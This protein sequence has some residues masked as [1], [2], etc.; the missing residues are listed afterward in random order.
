MVVV[1]VCQWFL[2]LLLSDEWG[3]A[4]ENG[5]LGENREACKSGELVELDEPSVPGELDESG[6]PDEYGKN[7]GLKEKSL[8]GRKG[9][10]KGKYQG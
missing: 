7:S 9:E 2:S 1:I 10:E 8:S 5:E 3:E 4:G 6:E